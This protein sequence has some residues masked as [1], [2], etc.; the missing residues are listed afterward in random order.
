MKFRLKIQNQTSQEVDIDLPDG[1]LNLQREL[2]I[3]FDVGD[4]SLLKFIHKGK[5]VNIEEPNSSNSMTENDL[6]TVILPKARPDTETKSGSKELCLDQDLQADFQSPEPLGLNFL[7]VGLFSLSQDQVDQL[8]DE[9]LDEAI[10]VMVEQLLTSPDFK[11]IRQMIRFN[12]QGASVLLENLKEFSP[13]FYSILCE[14]P[15]IGQHII[16]GVNEF[17]EKQIL[18]MKMLD[19]KTKQTKTEN[20]SEG[21][22]EDFDG[23]EE[24]FEYQGNSFKCFSPYFSQVKTQISK[25]MLWT[26]C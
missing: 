18:D 5:L 21:S 15:E 17:T 9:Q 16:E 12:P 6:I 11:P 1:F 25:G 19:K 22:W 3:K 8:D 23:S 24:N 26:S 2:A 13:P 10:S 7:A 14:N 20:D 4:H